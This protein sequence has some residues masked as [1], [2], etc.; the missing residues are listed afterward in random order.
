[1][2]HI[3]WHA[4][5]SITA[6]IHFV[7]VLFFSKLSRTKKKDKSV[8]LINMNDVNMKIGLF[9]IW[10]FASF[11]TKL[12]SENQVIS[13][14]VA[15]CCSGVVVFCVAFV[16]VFSKLNF[17]ISHNVLFSQNSRQKSSAFRKWKLWIDTCRHKTCMKKEAVRHF[18]DRIVR[19]AFTTWK[20]Q[21]ILR[22]IYNYRLITS[23]LLLWVNCDQIMHTGWDFDA[24]STQTRRVSALD[25][26]QNWS[27]SALF[28]LNSRA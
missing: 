27:A 20:A 3:R 15:G 13:R 14:A 4:G 25:R 5:K 7:F 24:S 11:M 2:C 22:V 18:G 10:W 26:H 21:V 17:V 1:M 9:G 8:S 28:C 12:Y 6:P 16:V 19:K 23:Y